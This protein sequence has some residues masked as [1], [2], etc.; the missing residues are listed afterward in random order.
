MI[1]HLNLVLN[2]LISANHAEDEAEKDALR[3]AANINDMAVE[4]GIKRIQS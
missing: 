4:F 3:H 1:S 2:Q